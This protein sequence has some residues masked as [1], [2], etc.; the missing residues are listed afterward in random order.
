MIFK[1]NLIYDINGFKV[2]MPKEHLLPVFQKKFPLYD[3]FLPFFIKKYSKKGLLIDIGAN[4]GDTLFAIYSSDN[5]YICIEG[6]SFFYDYLT[7]NINQYNLKNVEKFCALI[8]DNITRSVKLSEG[9][10]TK[11]AI[12]YNGVNAITYQ[13]LD[14]LCS[15]I[16]NLILLK[17]DVDGF[18]YDV[19]RS[20]LGLIRKFKPIIYFEAQFNVE[21]DMLEYLKLIE[22]LIK[23]HYQNIVLFDNFGEV[24]YFGTIDLSWLKNLFSYIFF[25]NFGKAARTIY[26]FDILL[27]DLDKLEEVSMIIEKYIESYSKK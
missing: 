12:D 17:S 7:F 11:Y 3:R 5:S 22:T 6:S 18:D 27:Y 24:L 2:K 25:Q 23:E 4:C 26:Y 20:G 19:I 14:D 1:R 16:E 15:N 13:R 10:S 21:S 9:R 8:G